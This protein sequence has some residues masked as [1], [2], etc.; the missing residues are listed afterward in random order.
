MNNNTSLRTSL[1]TASITAG[2]LLANVAAVPAEIEPPD[3]ARK[4]ESLKNSEQIAMNVLVDTYGSTDWTQLTSYLVTH[5]DDAGNPNVFVIP[6][7]LGN[8]FLNRYEASAD[9][10][11]LNRAL[12]YFE[13]VANYYGLWK[14][15]WLTPAVAHYLAVSVN[16]LRGSCD[17]YSALL[18]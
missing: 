13:W 8:V 18:P 9:L 2:L 12:P 3:F 16:R 11:D 14:E 4:G 5:P 15:R 10:G 7:S 1:L 6:L 17:E